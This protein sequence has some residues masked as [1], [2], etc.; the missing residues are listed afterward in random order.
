M[1]LRGGQASKA[2]EQWSGGNGGCGGGRL[3]CFGLD[4]NVDVD[5]DAGEEQKQRRA[6]QRDEGGDSE[7]RESA[8]ESVLSCAV[9][10][11]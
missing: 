3:F 4:V 1:M 11:W 6:G 2:E 9:L 8:L 5:V 10:S 7:W